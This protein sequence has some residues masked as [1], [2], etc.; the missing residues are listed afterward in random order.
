MLR[1]AKVRAYINKGEGGKIT[2]PTQIRVKKDKKEG[3]AEKGAL[4]LK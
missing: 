2:S 3:A 1:N 4:I